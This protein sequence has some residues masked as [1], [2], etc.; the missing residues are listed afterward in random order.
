MRIG[1]EAPCP[2]HVEGQP[3]LGDRLLGVGHLGG[4]HLGKVLAAQHLVAGEGEA[5]VDLD[6]GNFL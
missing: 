4:V 2:D 1:L 5:G 3:Q 6:L